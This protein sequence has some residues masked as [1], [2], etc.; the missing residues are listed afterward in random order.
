MYSVPGIKD[1]GSEDKHLKLVSCE[2]RGRC[3][4]KISKILKEEV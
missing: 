1:K 2:D 3:Q 4:K